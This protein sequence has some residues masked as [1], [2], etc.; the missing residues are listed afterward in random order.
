MCWKPKTSI[1]FMDIL[2]ERKVE[3][4]FEGHA[5]YDWKAWYLFDQANALSWFSTQNR[6]TYNITYNGG[7]SFLTLFGSNGFAGT[8]SYP[9]NASTA[10]LPYPE[11]ELLV[12]PILQQP[13]VA[14]D[15]SK[16]K[17]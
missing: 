11:S 4:A 13:P 17:Y 2:W 8:V 6:G 5:Y 10:D 9:I 15:F 3:F 12:A 14:F 7:K 1:S 16:V